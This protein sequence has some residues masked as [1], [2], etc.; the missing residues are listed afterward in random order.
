MGVLDIGIVIDAAEP[1]VL[2]SH[3]RYVRTY[4]SI[5]YNARATRTVLY[6]TQRAYNVQVLLTCYCRLLSIDM[7][8]SVLRKPL[9]DSH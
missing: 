3:V 1:P 2:L 9:G 8:S 6:Y 7:L 4:C 5:A